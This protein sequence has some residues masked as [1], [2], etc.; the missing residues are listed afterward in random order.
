MEIT[1][2]RQQ[3]AAAIT[4]RI[5]LN[6]ENVVRSLLNIGKDLRQMKVENLYTQ[7][8][9]ETFEDYTEN[10]V[11]IKSRQA[12][13]YIKVYEDLGEDFL[14]SNAS[15]GISKLLE[16]TQAAP[17]DRQKLIEENNLDGMTVKEVR[18]LVDKVRIQGEQL[19]LLETE[20]TDL[21]E[22]LENTDEAHSELEKEAS[23]LKNKVSELE[24]K[25][26]ELENRKPEI[27][28]K[29]IIKEVPDPKT[30]TALKEKEKEIEKLVKENKEA[31]EQ[32]KK[33]YESK[34]NQLGKA[35]A[36]D[37]STF[38]SIYASA[39]KELNGLIEFIRLSEDDTKATYTEAAVKLF[40]AGLNALT[41][42]LGG[43]NE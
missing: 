7:L 43:E 31:L 6:K 35:E 27:K 15:L 5:E 30:V 23:E 18:A 9:Y 10:A 17:D 3:E 36:S 8:G 11:S 32:Q 21:E 40:E 19:S 33:E 1:L 37:K 22:K 20:K 41:S 34:I 14:Q 16:L 4:A 39:F 26:S 2:N 38:K 42:N 28:E 24:N 25:V 13:N 12:Y 29:E